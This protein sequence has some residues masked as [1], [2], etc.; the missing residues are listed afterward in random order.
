MRPAVQRR[1]LAAVPA[2]VDKEGT[3]GRPTAS[4]HR[5]GVGPSGRYICEDSVDIPGDVTLGIC[6]VSNVIFLLKY[7]YP[8]YQPLR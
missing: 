5:R 8:T 6:T 7:S 1:A 3:G 2:L 4:T